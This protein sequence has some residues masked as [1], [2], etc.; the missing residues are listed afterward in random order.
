MCRNGIRKA[1][2]HVEL[3]L[4]RNMKGNKKG[5][6]KYIKSKKKGKRGPAAEWG[7]G[8]SDK[9]HRKG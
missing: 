3:N 7:R 2:A 1:K 5:S 6:H 4:S 9:R 8:H